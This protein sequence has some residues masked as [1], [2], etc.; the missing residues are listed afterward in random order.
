MHD[1][2]HQDTNKFHTKFLSMLKAD[3]KEIYRFTNKCLA[4]DIGPP[5]RTEMSESEV[6][7]YENR[8]NCDLCGRVFGSVYRCKRTGKL[9][10]ILK[11]PGTIT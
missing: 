8:K 3:V 11:N 1:P 5:K 7:Y 2:D 4:K 6:R 9:I 10:K